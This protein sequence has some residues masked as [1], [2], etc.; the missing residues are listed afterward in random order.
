MIPRTSKSPLNY[1]PWLLVHVSPSL[2]AAGPAPHAECLS[3][4]CPQSTQHSGDIR[5]ETLGRYPHRGLKKRIGAKG[6]AHL[7]ELGKCRACYLLQRKFGFS[8]VWFDLQK[9]AKKL[10]VC[11][12]IITCSLHFLFEG[13]NIYR[14]LRVRILSLTHFFFRIWTSWQSF[15]CWQKSRPF[16]FYGHLF[17]IPFCLWVFLFVFLL[18]QQTCTRRHTLKQANTWTLPRVLI[19]CR[20]HLVYLHLM[21]LCHL[22]N[23]PLILSVSHV[24]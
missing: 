11:F 19:K 24:T 17:F 6:L 22:T 18:T 14:R 16:L 10:F 9:F 5:C 4:H 13:H 23:L 3:S 7:K 2:A 20:S 12:P 15:S 1:Y 21:S 8:Q